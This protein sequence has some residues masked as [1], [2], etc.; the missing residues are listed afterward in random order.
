MS[1]LH[2]DP[3]QVS[4]T[5]ASLDLARKMLPPIREEQIERGRR[6]NGREQKGRRM[7]KR[8]QEEEARAEAEEEEPGPL[9]LGDL[10]PVA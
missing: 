1:H 9:V 8:Q 6:G 3:F 5:N 4:F 7:G 2:G 10:R